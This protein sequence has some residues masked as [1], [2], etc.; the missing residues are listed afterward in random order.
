MYKLCQELQKKYLNDP[1][2]E[3]K[4]GEKNKKKTIMNTKHKMAGINQNICDHILLNN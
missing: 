2:E 3:R 4:E 1:T